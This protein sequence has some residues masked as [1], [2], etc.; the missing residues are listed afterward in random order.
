MVVAASIR[1]Q[2]GDG[3]LVLFKRDNA[4]RIPI[5]VAWTG[6]RSLAEKLFLKKPCYLPWYPFASRNQL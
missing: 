1:N 6:Q 3:S 5:K 4:V 2:Q